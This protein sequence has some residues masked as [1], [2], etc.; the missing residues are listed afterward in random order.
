MVVTM[1]ELRLNITEE[2]VEEAKQQQTIFDAQKTYNKFE[3]KTNY[4]GL[5]GEMVFNDYLK[6]AGVD[7]EWVKFNKQGWNDPDFNIGG[8]SIDLKTTFSEVMWMQKP[9]FDIYIYGHLNKEENCLVLKGWLTKEEIKR[10]QESGEGCKIIE[11]EFGDSIRKDYI[12]ETTAMYDID[13]LLYFMN[14]TA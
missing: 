10:C 8:K 13:W 2:Q 12:F 7:F 14:V 3:C 4:I 11:R 9:K 6:N 1:G 5:L